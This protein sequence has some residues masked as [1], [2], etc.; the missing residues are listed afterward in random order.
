[1]RNWSNLG[2]AM[3]KQNTGINELSLK[4]L[5]NLIMNDKSIQI[6]DASILDGE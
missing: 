3:R 6:L 1:M 4:I 5:I 2:W